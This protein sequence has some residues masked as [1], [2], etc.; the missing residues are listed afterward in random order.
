V[1]RKLE[2]QHLRPTV[3]CDQYS[4]PQLAPGIKQPVWVH[5]RRKYLQSSTF[6]DRKIKIVKLGKSDWWKEN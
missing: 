6:R 4:L 1:G 2:P 3:E 5:N